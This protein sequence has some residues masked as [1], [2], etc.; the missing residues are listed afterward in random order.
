MEKPAISILAVDDE[1]TLLHLLTH[2]LERQGYYVDT[3]SDGRMAITMLQTLPFDLVF[4]DVMMP[5]VGGVEVLKFIKDQHLDAEVIMLTAVHDVKTAVE[6]MSLGAYYYITKPY[7]PA[8]LVGLVERALE[9]KR[10]VTQNKAFRRQIAYRALPTSMITKNRELL[11]TLDLAMRSAPTESPVLIQGATGTGK[12]VVANFIHANSLRKDQPLLVL[13]CASIPDELLESELFGHEEGAIH[14][15]TAAKQGLLEIAHGATLF[16][17]EI[18]ELPLK[19]QPKLMRFLQT[20]EFSRIGGTKTLKSDVRILSAT[21]KDLKREAAARKF[22][23]GLLLQLNVINLRLPP[24]KDRKEDI[25]LLVDQFLI[26]HA[27]S[28]QPKKLDEH[29]L[30]AL[31]NYDWPG[32]VRELESVVRRAAVLSEGDTIAVNHI[33]LPHGAPPLRKP[34]ARTRARKR[35]AG[36]GSAISLAKLEKAHMRSVLES[37]AWDK[38]R[39]A[40]V[41]GISVKTLLR[42]A[43][44]YKLRRPR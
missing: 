38:R 41:L 21:T 36:I 25:P 4:L 37:V 31:M 15:A 6:C 10:L 42:K 7:T 2:V 11:E 18:G 14:N 3:A 30:E 5:D 39:A 32:N 23:E 27:G 43:K 33:A 17:D 24:L 44:S 9:R 29:A 19:S 20:G 12:E 40:K 16:L 8:D 34:V 28:K 22:S 13:S 1:E 26:N 35:K